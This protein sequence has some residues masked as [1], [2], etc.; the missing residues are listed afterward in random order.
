M[1]AEPLQV[2][3]VALANVITKFIHAVKLHVATLDNTPEVRSSVR[4][5]V[6]AAI[7]NT[8]VCLQK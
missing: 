4:P 6:P 1:D 3:L 7:T 8:T 5:H 2:H